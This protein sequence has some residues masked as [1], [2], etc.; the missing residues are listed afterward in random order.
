M[1]ASGHKRTFQLHDLMSAFLRKQTFVIAAARAAVVA[2]MWLRESA[3]TFR[4]LV[5]GL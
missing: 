1:S 2:Y 4:D 5:A 3:P